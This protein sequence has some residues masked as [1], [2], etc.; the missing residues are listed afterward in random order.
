M[1]RKYL[2]IIL[3]LSKFRITSMVAVTTITGYLL[4]RHKLDAAFIL[5]TLGIF[6]LACSSS[7]LNHLQEIS[8]D[9]KMSRTS[10]R[11]L[12]NGTAS[13]SFAIVLSLLEFSIGFSL[14]LFISGYTSA[15]LGIIALI[16]YNGIY[17]PLK[18]KTVHAVIPGS[19]IGAIPP[20]VGWVAGGGELSSPK[21]WI[22]ALFFFV[23][24]VPHFYLLAYKFSAQYKNAGFPIITDSLSEK[25]IRYLIYIW[26]L[27]TSIATG[28]LQ[29]TGIVSSYI[30]AIF[31]FILVLWLNIEFIKIIIN[32]SVN[33]SPGKY[34]MK[35]NYFILLVVII[36]SVDQLFW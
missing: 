33:F 26:I 31:L 27:L 9:A 16:W 10:L 18:K 15:I 8:S 20:L 28:V 2:Y 29:V 32:K 23:W 1:F 7:V 17:T 11:P 12:P 6:F 13:K 21:A 3:E 36:L 35:I 4:A 14:L 25:S 34:F 22:I 30:S 5:P 19:V 24:Q